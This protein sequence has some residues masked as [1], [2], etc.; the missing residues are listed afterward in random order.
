MG[1]E[2]A[3]F[4]TGL[5]LFFVLETAVL[6][7][8]FGTWIRDPAHPIAPEP[9]RYLHAAVESFFMMVLTGF[10]LTYFFS[11]IDFGDTPLIDRFGY[12][13]I[14]IFFDTYPSNYISP[15]FWFFVAFLIV[16]FALEDTKRVMQFEAIGT[17]AKT[18]SYGG[19]IFLVFVSAFFTLSLAIDSSEDIVGHTIPFVA[20]IVAYPLVYATQFWRRL[21]HSRLHVVVITLFIATSAANAGFI[22]SNL[23]HFQ[24]PSKI[25]QFTGGLWVIFAVSAPF[26]FR[27]SKILRETLVLEN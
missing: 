22:I 17:T 9:E 5:A 24:I 14:C 1:T 19:N 8:N 23:A 25:A 6:V 15:V 26:I 12:N 21:S 11:D 20:L 7:Y 13:S 18:I 4:A 10:I 3:G 27:P 2:F 16:R